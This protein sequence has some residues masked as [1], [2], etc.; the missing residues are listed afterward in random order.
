MPTY[1]PVARGSA[2]SLR[3]PCPSGTS[4][5]TGDLNGTIIL[6]CDAAFNTV[7][8]SEVNV[9]LALGLG[10][11]LGIPVLC[12][13]M[14]AFYRCFQE[15]RRI[16]DMLREN[17]LMKIKPLLPPPPTP[18]QM[19]SEEAYKDFCSNTLSEILKR[20]VMI[21]RMKQGRDLN[22]FTEEALS[23]GSADVAGWIEHLYPGDIPNE[24]RQAANQKQFSLDV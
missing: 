8:S 9:E 13:I 22:E 17:T 16:S 6:I 14:F 1:Y 19:L 5:G 12:I 2:T 24:I 21:L 15:D 10:L 4:I 18:K 11:G 7:T 20:E 23:K 3:N